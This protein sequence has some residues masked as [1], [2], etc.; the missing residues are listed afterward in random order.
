MDSQQYRSGILFGLVAYISWGFVPIYFRAVKTVNPGSILAHR[1]VWS[2]LLLLIL[3]MM[4]GGWKDIVR[5]LRSR[6]LVLTLLLSA[7]LL[8]LNWL[9]Y[10]YAS[11]TNRVS[12]ASLGY[13]I[14]PLVNAFLARV[15][16]KE[17]L[18]PA[19]YPALALVL[20]GVMVPTVFAGE[21]TWIAIVL[22]ITFGLYGLVRKQVAVESFTGLT[23]ESLLMA[24][25]S[26]A[27]LVWMS[28]QGRSAFGQDWNMSVLLMFGAVVTVVPLLTFTLSIRRLPLLVNSFIQFLAPT[29]QLM[30]AVFLFKEA[31]S[32]ERWVAVGCVWVAVA[33]FMID[34]A[35]QWRQRS[36]IWRDKSFTTGDAKSTEKDKKRE[37][38]QI[39]QSIEI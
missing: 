27:Y 25:P 1:I 39:P 31:F 32:L 21:F 14:L 38:Q 23:V 19:H 34:A 18:R 8:S 15:V 29:M 7:L 37:N 28:T 2:L 22:P 36:R 26:F 17:Q 30:L 9:L 24:L 11:V 5:V 10:I 35:I 12:E 16:L 13:Y 33:I 20:V 4:I 6:K 3:A